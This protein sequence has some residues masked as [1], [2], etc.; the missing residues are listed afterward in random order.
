VKRH[1]FESCKA[2]GD[3]NGIPQV[4]LTRVA[5]RTDIR[6]NG[7]LVGPVILRYLIQR[8]TSTKLRPFY[9][10]CRYRH[11]DDLFQLTSGGLLASPI[12]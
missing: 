4:L 10:L 9:S 5:E 3:A 7:G 2:E 6:S 8:C 12:A 1:F 11:P